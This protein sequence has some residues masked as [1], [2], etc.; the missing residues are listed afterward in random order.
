MIEETNEKS[1]YENW[2]DDVM[3]ALE[4]ELGDIESDEDLIDEEYD[5]ANPK[6]KIDKQLKKEIK[7]KATKFKPAEGVQFV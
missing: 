1:N 5:I 4:N 6:S 3:T 2:M 7:E